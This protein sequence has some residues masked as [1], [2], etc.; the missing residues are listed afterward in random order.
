MKIIIAGA[1]DIGFYLAK[2]LS[3]ESQ[4]IYLIDTDQEKLDNISRSL[5]VITIHGD[6]TSA[7]VLKQL[8]IKNAGLLIAVTESQNT[9]FTIAAIGKKLGAKKTVARMDNTDI[10]NECDI[11]FKSLGIDI[12]ISP[13]ALAA[14]EIRS[15]LLRPAFDDFMEFE[16]GELYIVGSKLSRKSP[17]KGISVR[18]CKQTY[19]DINFITIALQ[20]ENSSRTIIADGDTT[21]HSGDH[22]YFAVPPES[23]DKI[24]KILGK[25]NTRIKDVMILGGGIIGRNTLKTLSQEGFSIKLI[26]KE[27]RTAFS[28][29]EEFPE[30]L[31]INADGRNVEMLDEENISGMDAFVAVTDNSET[32]I[33]SSLV[34]KTKGV[35]KT[36]ALVENIDYIKIS[37]AIGIDTLINKKLLAASGIFK[38]IRKGKVISLANTHTMDAEVLEFEVKIN[39]FVDGRSIKELKLSQEAVFCGI[40]RTGKLIMPFG[41]F[42]FQAEDRVIVFA[43]NRIINKLGEIFNK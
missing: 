13:K 16:N 33:M 32:N 14:E 19:N 21:F 22:V 20:R 35:K 6:A 40:V 36:I 31:I 30:V 42:V 34:A 23:I 9:N 37:Q 15:L 1:G 39:S 18:N 38:Y 24:H 26:E 25:P 4:D 12:V 5:D 28:I 17:I 10:F 29:A 43:L 41:D 27:K 2:L 11:D 3:Y 7:N 8:D